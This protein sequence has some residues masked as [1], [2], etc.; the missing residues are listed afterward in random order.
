MVDM[1]LNKENKPYIYISFFLLW[2]GMLQFPY[3]SLFESTGIR[4][5]R[6]NGRRKKVKLPAL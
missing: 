4:T 3:P 1:P 2:R 6:Y 5:D